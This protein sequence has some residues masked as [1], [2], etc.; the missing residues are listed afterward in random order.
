[1]K[2]LKVTQF[3]VLGGITII[4]IKQSEHLFTLQLILHP[5]LLSVLKEE[6]YM[7]SQ[8]LYFPVIEM[9]W[10]L[11]YTKY[12]I[13]RW[14]KNPHTFKSG[15]TTC[16]RVKTIQPQ[17]KTEIPNMPLSTLDVRLASPLFTEM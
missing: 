8:L 11:L 13:F 16:G 5:D 12:I 3:N 15:G 17:V 1:M 9:S 6:I 10:V 2:P 14:K 4:V 7:H